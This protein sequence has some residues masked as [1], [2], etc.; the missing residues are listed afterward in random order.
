MTDSLPPHDEN[1]QARADSLGR[2]DS[3][4][5]P[6]ADSALVARV[7]SL[8]MPVADSTALAPQ[9]PRQPR[10]R[11]QPFLEAPVVAHAADSVVYDR[12]LNYIFHYNQGDLTYEDNNLKGD[13]IAVDA[14]T[15]EIIGT[16]MVDSTGLVVRPEFVQGGANYTMDTVRFNLATRKALVQG[17][18]TQDGEGFMLARRMKRMPDG[19]MNGEQL[20]YTTCDLVEH[21]H[22]YIAM[23][24]ARVIPGKK[25]ITGYA[26]FVMEDVPIYFPGI[27][28]GFFPMSVGP[29]AGIVMPTWGEEVNRGFYL[30]G[31]G[32]YF[33]FGDHLDLKLTADIYTLG[34]WGVNA[35]SRY[36]KRYKY[37]GGFSGTYN[38]LKMGDPNPQ[39]S[40]T[41]SLTWNHTQDPK[42]NPRQNFS[43]N[44]NFQTAGQRQLATTS[45]QDHLNTSTTSSVSYSRRWEVGST[46]VN[47]TAAFNMTTSSRDSTINVTLPNIS[48]SVGSFAPFKRKNAIGQ[49]RWYEK[50]TVDYSMQAQ[51]Q[52]SARPGAT[53]NGPKE[54]E[55]FTR[56]TLQNL[57]NGVSHKVG[58]KTSLNLLGYI[59]FS[60]SFAYNEAWNF[61][62]QLQGWD[63]NGGTDG[64]GAAM[65]TIDP[66]SPNYIPPE[67]GFFRTY[68][69][70]INGSF[71]TKLYGVF[72]VKRREGK[73]GWLQAFRH[74]IT[75]TV[76]FTYAPDFT[77]P[78]YGFYKY[79]QTSSKGD[80][81]EY[82]PVIGSPRLTPG[83]ARASINGSISNQLEIKVRDGSD[84]TG[85]KKI[86]IIE[87]LSLSGLSW[88]FL[89]DSMQMSDVGISFRTGEIFKGFALQLSGNWTPY[90]F[91]DDGMGR[92]KQIRKFAIGRGKFGR[93]TSTSWSFGKTFN[94]PQGSSP[95]RGSI[96]SQLV[97]PYDAAYDPYNFA[98]GLNPV[99]RRQYMV[100]G[101]YDFNV[102]WSFTFNYSINYSHTNQRQPEIGQTLSFNG[103]VTLTEKWGFHFDSGYDF[104]RRKLSHMQLSLNRDLHCWEMSFNWVPM[105]PQKMYSFHIGI[106]AGMLRDIKYDKSSNSYDGLVR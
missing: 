75:P 52:T 11:D 97:N 98:N 8:G 58:M 17:V 10:R 69:W 87:Q 54:N 12:R 19:S 76:S 7:D 40:N 38:K 84:S 9:G 24:T 47:L 63:P 64:T 13:Y 95:G 39:S 51:N 91:V 74:M 27:P 72:E 42:A 41:I 46:S 102:P 99:L 82:M 81:K 15:R 68:D 53:G 86:T 23:T 30:R 101:W 89:K 61:K 96:Q 77:H 33:T 14:T 31:G 57:Q 59:N 37:S 49:Q 34:S 67:F 25:I 60:P 93:L 106:K 45:L 65:N 56:E 50:I 100:E 21:P 20:K 71:S 2:V 103:N 16:R 79:V 4:A 36:I 48:L 73:T 94:S 1:S 105:G 104:T 43:A 29:T 55:F 88:N 5:L 44:V 83:S 3:L 85:M 70:S 62:R 6:V 66:K 92:M 78:R 18:A 90:Q 28:G 80:V 35:T 26:Y 22:F 32:Y